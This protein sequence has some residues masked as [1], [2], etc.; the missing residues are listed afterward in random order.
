[1]GVPGSAYAVSGP[2]H[3]HLGD[4]KLS[5]RVGVNDRRSDLEYGDAAGPQRSPGPG[6]GVR[7]LALIARQSTPGEAEQHVAA[8]ESE[9]SDH[10]D[11]L[12]CGR[13]WAER[14]DENPTDGICDGSG[15]K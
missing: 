15:T 3:R 5:A 9:R 1:V 7:R 10:L 13:V 4:S 6:M 2:L 12:D 11:R 14:K 8:G